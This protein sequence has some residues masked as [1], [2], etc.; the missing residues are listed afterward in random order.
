MDLDICITDGVSGTLCYF[1]IKYAD[2][3][4]DVP[5]FSQ[6]NDSFSQYYLQFSQYYYTSND[7]SL[8]KI[9]LILF[10]DSL[11][12]FLKKDVIVC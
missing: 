1:L 3:S 8:Y 7:F 9:K 11:K 10:A 2:L 12:I 5:N 4:L 6:H